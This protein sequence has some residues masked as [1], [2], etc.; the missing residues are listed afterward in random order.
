MRCTMPVSANEKIQDYVN[1]CINTPAIATQRNFFNRP[2]DNFKGTFGAGAVELMTSLQAAKTDNLAVMIKLGSA[3]KDDKSVQHFYDA[4]PK[5][6]TDIKDA[7]AILKQNENKI[8]DTYKTAW[9]KDFIQGYIFAVINKSFM[10]MVAKLGSE[11]ALEF[12][13]NAQLLAIAYL[14]SNNYEE[15][16]AL[17]SKRLANENQVVEVVVKRYADAK[18][19]STEV[20][21]T[22]EE[23]T[24]I[25]LLPGEKEIRRDKTAGQIEKVVRGRLDEIVALQK[26]LDAKVT[27]IGGFKAGVGTFSAIFGDKKIAMEKNKRA[28]QLFEAFTK[29]SQELKSNVPNAEKKQATSE[30]LAI[31]KDL[32]QEQKSETVE[33]KKIYKDKFGDIMEGLDSIEKR[34][35]TLDNHLANKLKVEESK[36]DRLSIPVVVEEEV[37]VLP[38]YRA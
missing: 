19:Q 14:N 15:C 13:K 23:K 35:Q 38:R 16:F 6:A 4:L 7:L 20:K 11:S 18:S 10:N 37:A 36:S 3:N 32:K 25:D 27:K 12:Q 17:V 31:L 28:Q 8:P 24:Q 2:F 21:L 34:I 26:E 29:L 5:L 9:E 33:S 30:L 22:P 1:E